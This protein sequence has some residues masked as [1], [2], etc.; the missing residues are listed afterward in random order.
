M[1]IEEMKENEDIIL[2][3]TPRKRLQRLLKALLDEH[4]FFSPGGIRSVSKIHEKTYIVKINGDEYGLK[5][6]PGES[7]NSL[8]GGNSNWRGPVWMP[9]NYLLVQSLR[10]LYQHYGN[11]LKV[12]CPTGCDSLSNLD[13]IADDI[14]NSLISLFKPDENGKRPVHGNNPLYHNDPHFRDLILFYEYFH[15]D[16]GKGIGASHQTGWTGLVAELI[17]KLYKK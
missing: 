4:E 12:E 15:G 8:F 6:E 10:T 14:S 11:S 16:T 13:Q 2:S 17:H 9:M 3:L 7:S 5:Y 1:V